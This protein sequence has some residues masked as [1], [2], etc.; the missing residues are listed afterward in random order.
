MASRFQN[1]YVAVHP[2]SIRRHCSRIPSN[3]ELALWAL[4][5]PYIDCNSFWREDPC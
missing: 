3:Q 5:S 4:F 1:T 2:I